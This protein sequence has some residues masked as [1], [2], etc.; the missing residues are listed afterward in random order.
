MAVE[1]ESLNCF[2]NY[3]DIFIYRQLFLDHRIHGD[4]FWLS[5]MFDI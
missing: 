2:S 3:D 4:R 1:K 5:D